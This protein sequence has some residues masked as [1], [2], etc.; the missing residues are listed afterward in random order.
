MVGGGSVREVQ[1][2]SRLVDYAWETAQGEEHPAQ[3]DTFMDK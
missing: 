3:Y 2:N 1:A